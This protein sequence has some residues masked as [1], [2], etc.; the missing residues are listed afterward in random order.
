MLTTALRLAEIARS[1][2]K[3]PTDIG[4]YD[5]FLQALPHLYAIRPEPNLQALELLHQALE[6][7]S[8]AL[9]EVG[10]EQIEIIRMEMTALENLK[11]IHTY[12]KRIAREIVPQELRGSA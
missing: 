11:R 4:A 1:K 12:L 2:R 10:P 5:L 9:A 7:Q 8:G 3:P 6:L